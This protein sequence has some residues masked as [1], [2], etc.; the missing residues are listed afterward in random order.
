MSEDDEY[1][2]REVNAMFTEIRASMTRIETQT[3]KTNGRVAS[4]ERWQSFMQG[5][6]AILAILVVPLVIYFFTNRM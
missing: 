1:S 2:T 6:L 3:I 5:G 4:L